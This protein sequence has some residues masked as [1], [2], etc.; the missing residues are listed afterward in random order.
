MV[1]VEDIADVFLSCRWYI[2]SVLNLVVWLKGRL[3]EN[4][5]VDWCCFWCDGGFSL[6]LIYGPISCCLF[7]CICKLLKLAFFGTSF[8]MLCNL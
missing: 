5:W 8:V 3:Y 1:V 2:M 6:N 4:Y 7:L